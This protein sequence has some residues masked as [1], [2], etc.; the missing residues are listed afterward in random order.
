MPFRG[1]G[2]HAASSTLLFTG[3][4]ARASKESC[5]CSCSSCF[6]KQSDGNPRAAATGETPVVPVK[7]QECRFSETATKWD[8]VFL[9]AKGSV[10]VE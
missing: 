5:A 10:V 4:L 1:S 8:F 3:E 9:P 2:A 7:R 6:H